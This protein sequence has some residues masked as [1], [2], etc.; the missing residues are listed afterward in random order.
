M[1]YHTDRFEIHLPIEKSGANA[2]DLLADACELSKQHLKRIMLKGAVWVS[3]GK[4]KKRM[5]RAKRLL[6][7]GEKLK[8]YYEKKVLER[9]KEEKEMIED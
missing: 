2:V 7:D 6:K 1:S 8:S 4:K 9:E 3:V 5:R